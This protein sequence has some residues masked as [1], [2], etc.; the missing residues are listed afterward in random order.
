MKKKRSSSR[1]IYPPKPP[2]AQI[3]FQQCRPWI[4]ARARPQIHDAAR[5]RTESVCVEIGRA[6]QDRLFHQRQ[7]VR[8][9]DR[10]SILSVVF[11]REKVRD[12][13]GALIS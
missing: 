8:Q 2:I 10:P 12:Q 7:H 3:S 5:H 13:D 1:C 11:L 4:L 6:G 9:Q